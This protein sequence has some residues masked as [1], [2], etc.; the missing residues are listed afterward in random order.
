LQ[1]SGSSGTRTRLEGSMPATRRHQWKE[2]AGCRAN[3][4]VDSS[5]DPVSQCGPRRRPPEDPLLRK[6]GVRPVQLV[7][8]PSPGPGVPRAWAVG[9]SR[10]TA[11]PCFQ[12]SEGKH[13][14]ADFLDH[15]GIPGARRPSA[16]GR[17]I[18]EPP[19][20]PA[21]RGAPPPA[22][23]SCV[24]IP[25]TFPLTTPARSRRPAMRS[26]CLPGNLQGWSRYL[27]R[28]TLLVCSSGLVADSHPAGPKSLRSSRCSGFCIQTGRTPRKRLL[29]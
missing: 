17:A 8:G 7:R 1:G 13:S 11:T 23:P 5:G 14:T 24:R 25:T 29:R 3:R 19:A 16:R 15:T 12:A 22:G 10:V 18:A 20:R 6:N 4:R 21:R 28:C 26:G 9:G 2:R 27:D